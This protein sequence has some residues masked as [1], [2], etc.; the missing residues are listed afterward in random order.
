MHRLLGIDILR[1]L[2]AG[3]VLL[4]HYTYWYPRQ[5]GIINA[6][7]LTFIYGNYGVELFFIIS[8][9]VIFMTVERSKALWN[10]VVSRVSRL[11]PAFWVAVAL[12]TIVVSVS[13]VPLPSPSISQVAANATMMPRL[14]R[15]AA[16]D[17]VYWTLYYEML[18]YFLM[19]LVLATGNLARI[20]MVCAAWLCLSLFIQLV[21]PYF[22]ADSY[23]I[24][25]GLTGARCCNLFVIGIM[26]YRLKTQKFYTPT[27]ILLI[28]AILMSAWGPMLSFEPI[29]RVVYVSM[30]AA[31]AGL[32]WVTVSYEAL[33]SWCTPLLFLGDIS[34]S[35]YLIHQNVGYSIMFELD[36]YGI[37]YPAAILPAILVVILLA[38]AIRRF[39]EIPCQRH[40]RK[41][42]SWRNGLPGVHPMP[43]T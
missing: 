38:A 16:I 41:A 40:L 31:F 24:A 17:P 2:A 34:Y 11:Y 28:S 26:L 32:V 35:L 23:A 22:S 43:R 25:V 1:G 8:G 36:D 13:R 9:F 30:I 7:P 20:G 19:A 12:T 42:L 33:F 14:F 4:Y 39:I 27:V 18:F 6:A 10:F 29:S 37:S 21:E 5:F 15:F 3:A